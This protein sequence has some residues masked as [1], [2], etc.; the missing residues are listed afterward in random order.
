MTPREFEK[1]LAEAINAEAAE[2]ADE[3]EDPIRAVDTY[4]EAGIL[5]SDRGLVVRF[6]DGSEIQVTLVLSRRGH[7]NATDEE[8]DE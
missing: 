2:Q 5:T 7:E 4:E 6:E 8:D 1:W 3:G